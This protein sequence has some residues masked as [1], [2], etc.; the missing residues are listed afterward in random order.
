VKAVTIL[1]PLALGSAA[2]AC[3]LS[4][5]AGPLDTRDAGP[6]I[7]DATAAD[8]RYAP[9]TAQTNDAADA[10]TDVFVR[11]DQG[12]PSTVCDGYPMPR[13]VRNNTC[14]WLSTRLSSYMHADQ[15]LACG[16]T[17]STSEKTFATTKGSADEDIPGLLLKELDGGTEDVWLDLKYWSNTSWYWR[18]NIATLYDLGEHAP[19][20]DCVVST[21]GMF[22]KKIDC[23]GS[24]LRYAVCQSR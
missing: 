19:G 12:L 23:T 8:V 1:M 22:I 18:E 14:F 6:P 7:L 5:T 2:L 10:L 17:V 3:G 15:L 4:L 20:L 21:R 13:L 11:P 16:T 9:D 24:T